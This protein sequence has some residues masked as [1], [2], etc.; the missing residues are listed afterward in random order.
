MY[1]YSTTKMN[2]ASRLLSTLCVPALCYDYFLVYAL[3]PYAT[4]IIIE[5]KIDLD[6]NKIETELIGIED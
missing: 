6:E 4:L 1:L 5:S 3:R 2:K